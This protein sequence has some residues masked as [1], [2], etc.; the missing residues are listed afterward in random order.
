[1]R[2]CCL[3]VLG[4]LGLALPAQAARFGDLDI[5]LVSEP[6]GDHQHGYTEYLFALENKSDQPRRVELILPDDRSFAGG[7]SGFLASVRRAVEVPANRTVMLGLPYPARP[8]LPGR[9]IRVVIDGQVMRDSFPLVPRIA[10]NPNWATGRGRRGWGGPVPMRG[11]RIGQP[12]VLYSQAFAEAFFQVPPARAANGGIDEGAGWPG[13]PGGGMFPGRPP[14]ANPGVQPGAPPRPGN[15]LVAA[16]QA[17]LI[18]SP[19][20]VSAWSENWLAYTRYDALMLTPADLNELTVSSEFTRRILRAIWRY[21][22]AGGVVVVVGG[23][24]PDLPKAWNRPGNRDGASGWTLYGM[25]FGICLH[26]PEVNSQ[27]WTRQD[28]S[29]LQ[30]AANSTNQ[31][32]LSE[33]STKDLN[34]SFPV[35]DDLGVPVGGMFALMFL[36][37][38]VIGPVNLTL[39]SRIKRRIWML[40]TVPTLSAYTCFSVLCY[41]ILAEGWSGHARVAGVTLLDQIEERATSLGRAAYYSPLTPSDG[42]RFAEDVELSVYGNDSST[43]ENTCTLEWVGQQHFARGWVTARVPVHYR[44]RR[45][46]PQTKQR[47]VIT[48]NRDGSLHVVNALGADLSKLSLADEKGQLYVAD[49]RISAGQEAILQ[50]R[51]QEITK[52]QL[53]EVYRP[54]YTQGNWGVVQAVKNLKEGEYLVPNSYV[55]VLEQ[56]PFLEQGLAWAARKPSPSLVVGVF[57][58]I[59]DK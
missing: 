46:E 24:K 2:L 23:A 35:V 41:M 17:T 52:R 57:G 15:V 44:L 10:Q 43:N 14:G 51:G 3:L 11:G 20:P 36:F 54:L 32:W 9:D 37:A 26:Q 55:A 29:V 59:P 28:W 21:A 50:Q 13:E 34:S 30:Q 4:L 49:E 18:R 27:R 56:T 8:T 40:W 31:P 25:G 38:V 45:S 48:R 1:M 33:P 53:H 58:D 5:R 6:L 39:L 12:L 42:L 47:L 19:V 22:E 16:L 7:A